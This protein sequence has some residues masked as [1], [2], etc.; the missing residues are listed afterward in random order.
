MSQTL[1]GSFRISVNFDILIMSS[2]TFQEHYDGRSLCLQCGSIVNYSP[3]LGNK[4]K[5]KKMM[6]HAETVGPQNQQYNKPQS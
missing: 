4:K 5:N 3:D 1:S 6:E 2:E